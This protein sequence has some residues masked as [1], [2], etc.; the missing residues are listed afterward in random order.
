M[1]LSKRAARM[2]RQHKRGIAAPAI[3]LVSLMDIFTILVF[4]LL[5]NSSD[6]EVLPSTR[7]VELPESISEAK[8]RQTLVVMVTQDAI[9]LQGEPV[10]ELE[11]IKRDGLALP[12]LMQ[13]LKDE[14]ARKPRAAEDKAPEITIMGHKQTP[15]QLL[16]RVMASCTEAGFSHVSLAVMQKAAQSRASQ[17]NR[18]G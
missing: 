9:L 12:S 16:K 17:S 14:A 10:T 6:G 4:F 13:A 18:E 5:V 3:N 2:Q 11:S 1:K 7:N 15:Y 8:P